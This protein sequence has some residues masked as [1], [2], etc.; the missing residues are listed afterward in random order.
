MK[1]HEIRFKNQ[2]CNYSILIGK[3]TLDLTKGIL[4][5]FNKKVKKISIQ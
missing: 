2:D 1:N 5:I 4:E 3:N